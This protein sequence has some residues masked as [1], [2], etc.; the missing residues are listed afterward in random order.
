MTDANKDSASEKIDELRF[1]WSRHC[2]CSLFMLL[3]HPAMMGW[4]TLWNSTIM[5]FF[6][7][8]QID[9]GGVW[10]GLGLWWSVLVW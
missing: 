8:D 5:F 2:T 7:I 9:I 4:K 6:I 3:K 1:L 10:F